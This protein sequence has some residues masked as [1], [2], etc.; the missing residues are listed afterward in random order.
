MNIGKF[1]QYREENFQASRWGGMIRDKRKRPEIPT[2]R[3]FEGVSEMPV[4]GQKNLL[5]LD[6]FFKNARGMPMAWQ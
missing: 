4:F 1:R 2:V 5:E 6:A 3:I